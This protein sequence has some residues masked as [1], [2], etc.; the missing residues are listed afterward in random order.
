ER[1]GE[2]KRNNN[3]K[4]LQAD[5]WDEIIRQRSEI[6]IQQGLS[7]EFMFEWLNAIHKESIR[8]QGNVMNHD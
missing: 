2:Y 4:I 6:G 1:I 3:I 5:R 8:H 7:A